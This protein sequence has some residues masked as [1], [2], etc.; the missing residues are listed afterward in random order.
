MIGIVQKSE[1]YV[2]LVSVIIPV[3]NTEESYLR[4]CLRPFMEHTDSRIEIIIVDD[5]SQP[6]TNEILRHLVQRCPNTIQ[7][8]HR[9]NG[10]QN[11][12]RNAGLDAAS[13]EYVEFIDSDDRID[14]QSQLTVMDAL[15]RYRPDILGIN[16]ICITP[17]GV[18]TSSW[19]YAEAGSPYREVSAEVILWECSALWRQIVRRDMFEYASLRLLEG[20]AIGEDLACVVPLLLSATR[21]GVVGADLY[22]CVERPTSVTHVAHPERL[23]DITTAFDFIL[24]WARLRVDAGELDYARWKPQ[25]ERLAI[26]HIRFAGVARAVDWDGVHSSSIPKLESY[27]NRR[28]PQWGNNELYQ[29]DSSMHGLNYR[30]VMSRHYGMYRLCLELKR[31]I[32]QFVRR[33]NYER[34]S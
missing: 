13:G 5:G 30:L 9:T 34:R 11:A 24:D 3:Y 8:L 2:P 29:D 16:A 26:K 14:W 27:M 20:I 31:K 12:A 22:Y 28:F 1:S 33:K 21:V 25:I 6:A 19:R 23:L 7:L 4:D 10:G 18:P 15:E 17:S 32:S